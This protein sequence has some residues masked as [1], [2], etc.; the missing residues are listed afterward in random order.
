MDNVRRKNEHLTLVWIVIWS[1]RNGRKSEREPYCE[2][3]TAFS[4]PMC[5]RWYGCSRRGRNTSAT[6]GRPTLIQSRDRSAKY[7]RRAELTYQ[8]RQDSPNSLLVMKPQSFYN[9]HNS[10]PLN[11]N[12]RRIKKLYIQQLKPSIARTHARTHT[13]RRSSICQCIAE[14]WTSLYQ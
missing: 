13:L 3:L 6:R 9:A 8:T 2:R 4:L 1:G 7:G 5:S 12:L 10:L 11:L 14:Y